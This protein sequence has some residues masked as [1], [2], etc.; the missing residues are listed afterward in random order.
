MVWALPA[1]AQS[2][3]WLECQFQQ[4]QHHQQQ[5]PQQYQRGPFGERWRVTPHPSG[6]PSGAATGRPAASECHDTGQVTLAE[7]WQAWLAC[8]HRKRGTQD[9]LRYSGRLLDHLDATRQALNAHSWHPSRA[10]VFVT[11]RPKAREIHAPAFADRVV[12]HWLVPQLE[13]MFE[14]LFIHDSYANRV[15]KG[16]HAAVARLQQFMRQ[17]TRNGQVPAWGLQLDVANC[18]NTI[19]RRVLFGLLDARLHKHTRHHPGTEARA[20]L[21]RSVTRAL[22]TGNPA[23]HA[24]RLGSPARFDRVPPH[25]RLAQ[26]APECGLAIGNLS[27]QFFAN[28]YLDQLNQFVKHTLKCRHYLRYVDDFVLLAESTSQL[29]AWRLSIK[30]FLL[31][32][33]HM[34]LRNPDPPLQPVG[35][36]LDFLGYL[37]RPSHLLPR[38]RVVQALRQ[39]LRHT[40]HA[41]QQPGGGWQLWPRQQAHLQGQ[42]ASYS[43]HLRHAKAYRVVQR[44]QQQHAWAAPWLNHATKAPLASQ[45]SS[46]HSWLCI[47]Y[48]GHVV[49]L[50]VGREVLC[51]NH[52]AQQVAQATGVALQPLPRAGFGH[53]LAVPVGVWQRNPWRW[54]R[55]CAA[56]CWGGWG[57]V[58][59]WQHGRVRSHRHGLRQ[60]QLVAVYPPPG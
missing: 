31:H 23:T 10:R 18:F 17:A 2:L 44:L 49:W 24:R 36:G 1:N 40:Q 45:L 42:W 35:Q 41:A 53:T 55:A 13:A 25:K 4:R 9:C 28:V 20:A 52:H 26:A 39:R 47:Q 21:L 3:Q 58:L 8:R 22:L 33:L 32:K 11:T 12:H 34:T 30:E 5:Q 14:P 54:L 56:A 59:A 6:T 60:R 51:F 15:G 7:L 57:A 16:T 46:Q 27:S 19:N 37:V 48:P 50:Q 43:G 38:P 29:E